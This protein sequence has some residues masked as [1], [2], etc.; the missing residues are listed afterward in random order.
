STGG[1]LGTLAGGGNLNGAVIAHSLTGPEAT[2]LN[3]I[4]ITSLASL[5]G[6]SPSSTGTNANT[7]W[8]ATF[9]PYTTNPPTGVTFAGSSGTGS[10][11]TT[12]TSVAILNSS[13]TGYG[14]AVSKLG[15]SLTGT[16][17]V[18]GFGSANTAVG[19]VMQEA[20]VHFPDQTTINPA[21]FYMRY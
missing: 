9:N 1:P 14:A 12:G 15:L 17:V 19:K 8:S 2:A 3:N 18:L 20:P 21:N 5:T 10:G 4:G 11:A 13:W 16:Y 7:N 6:T